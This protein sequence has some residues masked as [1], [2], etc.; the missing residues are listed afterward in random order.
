MVGKEEDQEGSMNPT[1][2]QVVPLTVYKCILSNS[3]PQSSS[4]L[5]RMNV[6]LNLLQ[7]ESGQ[8]ATELAG[9]KPQ[10]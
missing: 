8:E 1:V 10:G 2:F 7:L 6:L 9:K 3:F 4:G 5:R